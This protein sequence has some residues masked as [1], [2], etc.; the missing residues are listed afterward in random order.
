MVSVVSLLC[1]DRCEVVAVLEGAAVVEPVD[2]FRG[3][4][5]EVVEALPRPSRRA[6]ACALRRPHRGCF[7]A[8]ARSRARSFCSTSIRAGAASRRV[9]RCWPTTRQAR[10]WETPNIETGRSTA[11][12][13]RSGPRS[14]PGIAP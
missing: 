1:F 3:G 11:R 2:P 7:L 10:R 9:E 6:I 14:F 8:I 13:R 5:L 4:D 12:R